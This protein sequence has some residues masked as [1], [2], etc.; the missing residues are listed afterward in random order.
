MLF[1]LAVIQK[2]DNSVSKCNKV[3]TTIPFRLNTS[4]QYAFHSIQTVCHFDYRIHEKEFDLTWL[5]TFITKFRTSCRHPSNCFTIKCGWL[6]T[7]CMKNTFEKALF[8]CAIKLLYLPSNYI[9][10]WILLSLKWVTTLLKIVSPFVS[11]LRHLAKSI[12]SLSNVTGT[13]VENYWPKM[14]HI[15]LL[16]YVVS[17]Y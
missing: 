7:Q 12:F 8:K 4:P 9:F 16:T 15:L 13:L 14:R 11:V 17:V 2:W 6:I 3:K 1:E 10:E 5:T